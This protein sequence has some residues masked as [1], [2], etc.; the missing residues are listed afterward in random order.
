MVAAGAVLAVPAEAAPPRA[1]LL[2]PVVACRTVAEATARLACFDAAVAPLAAAT[3]T[4]DVRVVD[5]EDVRRTRRSLFGFNLPKLPFFTGDDSADDTPDTVDAVIAA[6][7][8]EGYGRFALTMAD[9]AVWRTTETLP[10]DPRPGGKVRLKRAALGG[11]FLGV[12]G[13]RVVRALRVR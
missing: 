6:V 11:Y 1:D 13:G 12:D 10:R 4:G 5:R 9:G 7:A 2:A 8:G 3:S